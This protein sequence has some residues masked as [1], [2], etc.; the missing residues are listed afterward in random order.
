[1]TETP[2]QLAENS[3][4]QM[5]QA[6]IGLLEGLSPKQVSEKLEIPSTRISRW[7]K[8]PAFRELYDEVEAELLAQV[9]SEAAEMIS[10]RL[11]YLG[12]AAVAVLEE[13]L[14]AEKMSDRLGAAKAI[15]AFKGVGKTPREATN[16]HRVVSI[17]AKIRQRAVDVS[18]AAGD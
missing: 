16:A 12:P 8:D 9:K 15:L 3:R 5:T 1:M 13:G 18:P 17:E 11:D 6:I 14:K 4:V 10:A 2:R 7:Q